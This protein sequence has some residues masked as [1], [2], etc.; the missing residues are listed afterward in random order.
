LKEDSER[1]TKSN[2]SFVCW[3]VFIA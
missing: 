2:D 3:I 1:K